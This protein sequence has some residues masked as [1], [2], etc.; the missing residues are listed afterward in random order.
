MFRVS[1]VIDIEADSAEAAARE[2][3]AIQRKP[4]S[5]AT[6][7]EVKAEGES[8][9]V[10]V[11]LT[12]IDEG[13]ESSSE[14]DGLWTEGWAAAAANLQ[15]GVTLVMEV[16]PCRGSESEYP[17]WGEIK[18]D[19]QLLEQIA[20]LHGVCRRNQLASVSID[21][22]LDRWAETEE[23]FSVYREHLV[24][25]PREFCFAGRRDI[26]GMY[27]DYDV[28]TLDIGIRELFAALSN[29]EKAPEGWARKGSLLFV[30]SS[31]G[32]LGYLRESYAAAKKSRRPSR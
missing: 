4:D 29:P 16:L 7:F 28:E 18:L 11:D 31:A 14:E 15:A 2:A 22:A 6:V 25:M 19:P 9:P 23:E 12:E 20:R 24:V 17:Q 26:E 5:I 13:C 27:A 32:E 8:Q 3:L 10:S 21:M 1:W 30:A